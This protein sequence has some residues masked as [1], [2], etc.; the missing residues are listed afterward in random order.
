M[1]PDQ[2]FIICRGGSFHLCKMKNIGRAI[3]LIDNSFDEFPLRLM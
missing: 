3:L 2:E 1:N